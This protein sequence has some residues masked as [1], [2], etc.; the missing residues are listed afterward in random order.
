MGGVKSSDNA[1]WSNTDFPYMCLKDEKRTIAFREA[2]RRV[3]K[4]GDVV[5][6][7]GAG[8]GIL[9]FFAVEAGAKKVYAVEFEPLLAKMLRKSIVMNGLS[10]KVQVVEANIL[11]AELPTS[12]DVVIAEI[13]DTGLIDEMQLLAM[14]SLRKRGIITSTTRLLPSKYHTFAELMYT[15][16]EYYGYKI[17]TIKHEWPFYGTPN[18]RTD[19][20]YT[21]RLQ[22]VSDPVLISTHDFASGPSEEVVDV[23]ISFN[24]KSEDGKTCVANA[25]KISGIITLCTGIELGATNALNG[26]KIIH[27]DDIKDAT[28]RIR[29]ET[30]KG[31]D[32]L[33]I[34]RC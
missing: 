4:P 13:I 34:E 11:T 15:D 24:L 8:S 16:N 6:D 9:S 12:V 32:N 20:W 21:T 25:L 7:V 2:I 17:A 23:K 31:L 27:I 1:I 26:D 28:L 3:V 5:V 14:N 29:Y 10:E 19:G 30:G 22:S 33:L 18:A